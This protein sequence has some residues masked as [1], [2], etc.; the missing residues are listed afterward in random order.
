MPALDIPPHIAGH[1]AI[2][3]HDYRRRLRSSA[4]DLPAELEVLE[5][6]LLVHARGRPGPTKVDEIDRILHALEQPKPLLVTKET[7]AK[8]LDISPRTIERFIE[9]GSMPA[10]KVNAST[11]IR[12]RDL[13]ALVDHLPAVH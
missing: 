2:A 6:K 11:R 8:M 10:V 3:I 13:E 4:C 9:K 1:L 12:P 5:E 7:A